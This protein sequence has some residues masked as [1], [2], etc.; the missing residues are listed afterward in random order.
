MAADLGF[1]VIDSDRD[2]IRLAVFHADQ[3][4]REEIY[5]QIS[6]AERP[7]S[8]QKLQCNAKG[9]GIMTGNSP[10]S[11]NRQFSRKSNSHPS[12]TIGL[13]A[14][15]PYNREEIAKL[16]N[17]NPEELHIMLKGLVKHAWV[18]LN[19]RRFSDALAIQSEIEPRYGSSNIAIINPAPTWLI[20]QMW[21][22]VKHQR[23][24]LWALYR[25]RH[26]QPLT[27]IGTYVPP[28]AETD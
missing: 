13:W 15:P 22:G 8:Q 17:S 6:F 16:N 10:D 27:R 9:F 2:P 25:D 3:E 1:M 23:P 20:D 14:T 19:A 24:P 21:R 7:K 28:V 12:R 5:P 11:I 26:R 18:M 4:N